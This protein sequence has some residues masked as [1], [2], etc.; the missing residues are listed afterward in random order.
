MIKAVCIVV[1]VVCV[2]FFIFSLFNAINVSKK[3]KATDEITRKVFMASVLKEQK[4]AEH[5]SNESSSTLF[6]KQ[7]NS[8][9]PENK[10][11]LY[12]EYDD[13]P[14][15]EVGEGQHLSDFLKRNDD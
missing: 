6:T 11:E 5:D 2:G 10:N 1:L 4:L 9:T 15:E 3:N 7:T 8:L 12:D 13:D 14:L